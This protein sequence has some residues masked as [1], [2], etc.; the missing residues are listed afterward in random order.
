MD[1]GGQLALETASLTGQSGYDGMYDGSP[2]ICQNAVRS[3]Q[4]EEH[5]KLSYL[6]STCAPEIR[7]LRPREI[8]RSDPKVVIVLN[9][10]NL[11]GMSAE[12]GLK[13]YAVRGL[14]KDTTTDPKYLSLSGT[15]HPCGDSNRVVKF[16]RWIKD[17]SD[18]V[19]ANSAGLA[20]KTLKLFRD[21]IDSRDADLNENIADVAKTHSSCDDADKNKLELGKVKASDGSCWKHVHHLEYEVY[22]LTN[23]AGVENYV[24][25]GTRFIEVSDYV[26]ESYVDDKPSLGRYGDHVVLEGKNIVLKAP[27][28]YGAIQ[29]QFKTYEF[30]PSQR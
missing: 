23:F 22:D 15:G 5:C 20:S 9:D 30:N 25:P 13:L 29:A 8:P 24:V 17:E 14:V 18:S 28:S 1:G 27:L 11:E 7:E 26:F 3:Y 10:E 6:P 16:S 2:V 4:N 12:S 19:C 21:F